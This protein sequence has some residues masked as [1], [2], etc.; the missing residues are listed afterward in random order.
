MS[1][2]FVVV[3]EF[4]ALQGGKQQSRRSDLQIG[5]KWE[6]TICCDGFPWGWHIASN[7]PWQRQPLLCSSHS[8]S[9]GCCSTAK[10]LN[11]NSED[12]CKNN[13]C[14]WLTDQAALPL[15]LH[16]EILLYSS[17]NAGTEKNFELNYLYQLRHFWKSNWS[18]YTFK[19]RALGKIELQR[20]NLSILDHSEIVVDLTA[21][22]VHN[23][24]LRNK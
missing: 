2:L 8:Y 15:L 22:F 17:W 11:R 16:G 4:Q 13:D 19:I 10:K 9:T 20:C 21:Y 6:R 7:L 5:E 12:A 24:F 3:A 18:D 1:V 14:Y 23:C